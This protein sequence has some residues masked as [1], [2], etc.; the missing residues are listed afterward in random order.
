MFPLDSQPSTPPGSKQASRTT[1]CEL[2]LG[3]TV[4]SAFPVLSP[5]NVFSC[6]PGGL[7]AGGTELGAGSYMDPTADAAAPQ[8]GQQGFEDRQSWFKPETSR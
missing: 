3:D 6:I 4:L 5:R 1:L 8:K 7:P 2:S